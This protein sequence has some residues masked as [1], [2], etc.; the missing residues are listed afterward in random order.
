MNVTLEGDN[1]AFQSIEALCSGVPFA[2]V[3]L[4][5][6]VERAG[7]VAVDAEEGCEDRDDGR[8]HPGQEE[9]CVVVGVEA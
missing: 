2:F 4:V 5:E 3:G 8:H 7:P 9:M 6:I 1:V